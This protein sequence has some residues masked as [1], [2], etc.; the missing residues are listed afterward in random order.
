MKLTELTITNFRGIKNLNITFENDITVIIGENNCGKSSI[1]D[2][3]YYCL[4][5][6]KYNS[7]SFTFTDYDFYRNKH[8]LK[9]SE[10]DPI[11]ILCKFEDKSGYSW[12]SEI[13]QELDDVIVGTV[14]NTININVN[15]NYD[16]IEREIKHSIKFLDNG[17]NELPKNINKNLRLFRKIRPVFYLPAFRDAHSQFKH[18]SQFWTSFIK[19]E[20]ID[21][22]KRNNFEMEL[23]EIYNKILKNHTPF[24]G[25]LNEINRLSEIVS[26]SSANTASIDPFTSSLIKTLQNTEVN[27]LTQSGAKI[28]LFS[29]GAGT[30]SIAVLLLFSAYFQSRLKEDYER[31]S[32]PIILIEEPEAHLHPNATRSLFNLIYSLPGQKIIVT[33]SGDILS[34]VPIYN[35]KR[36]YHS[37]NEIKQKCIPSTLLNSEEIRKIDYHLR[38]RRGELFFAKLWLFVE[39]ETDYNVF[40][41]GSN[42]LNLDFHKKGIRIIEYSQGNLTTFIKL[43]DALGI[44]WFVVTDNDQGGIDYLNEAKLLLNGRDEKIHMQ[45][46]PFQNMDIL[47][48]YKSGDEP[49]RRAINS[50]DLLSLSTNY[51]DKTVKFYEELYKKLPRKFSKPKAANEV[52]INM[53]PPNSNP[54]PIEIKK[55][56]FHLI[57][58]VDGL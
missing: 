46:I 29:H 56:I 30:Q 34:E 4:D 48:C 55:I 2:A 22:S 57:N 42:I 37:K 39:G 11:N 38:L 19:A 24:F 8:K 7:N 5:K 28:P 50:T 32:E 25:I 1:L 10:S 21:N 54:L 26:V 52:I 27:I 36:I 16:P 6:L 13:V 17:G 12:A 51:G 47:L 3:I 18:S 45:H 49:Y 33:H 14:N 31:Y 9:I 53:Y 44:H 43:A 41:N 35:I 15:S 23:E 58:I 40:L 20:S